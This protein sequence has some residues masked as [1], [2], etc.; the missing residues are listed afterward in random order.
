MTITTTITSESEGV[1][2]VAFLED[3]HY[4]DPRL[5]FYCLEGDYKTPMDILMEAWDNA[6]HLIDDLYPELVRSSKL[7]MLPNDEELLTLLELSKTSPI[8]L[9]DMMTK[10]LEMKFFDQVECNFFK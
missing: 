6:T 7:G 10:A 8:E 9:K 3:G 1:R 5:F 2:L 4:K